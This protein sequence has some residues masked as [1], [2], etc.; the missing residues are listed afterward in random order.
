[1]SAKIRKIWTCPPCLL[2]YGQATPDRRVF[3]TETFV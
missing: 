1:M 3:L 2:T